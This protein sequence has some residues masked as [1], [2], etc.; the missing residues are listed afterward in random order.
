M[1]LSVCT[2]RAS[3][4][5]PVPLSPRISTEALVGATFSTMRQ[6]F[7]MPSSV[8]MMPSSGLLA[9]DCSQLPVLFL[10]RVDVEGAV[11]Q[12]PQDVG[13]HG[14]LVEVVGAECRRLSRRCRG[15]GCP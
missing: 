2:A 10:E 15:R 12:Q 14:L 11:H 9:C 1:A 4:S 6:T 5:L 13:V 3:S 8:A 7:S